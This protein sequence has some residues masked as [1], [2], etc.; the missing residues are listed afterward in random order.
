MDVDIYILSIVLFL[1]SLNKPIEN[2]LL[3]LCKYQLTTEKV[4]RHIVLFFL[5]FANLRSFTFF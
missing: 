1:T 4:V 3:V 5:Y 2:R